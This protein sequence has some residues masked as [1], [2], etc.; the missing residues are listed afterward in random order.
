MEGARFGR[1]MIGW[2]NGIDAGAVVTDFPWD[3]LPLNT[4]V[5]DVGGGV[6]NISMQLLRKHPQLRI[7]LQDMPERIKQAKEQVWPD[8]FP[9]ALGSPND[10]AGSMIEF[11]PIDFLKESPIKDCD[12]YFL[13]NII[14]DWPDDECVTILKHIKA[15]MKADSRI[16]IHEYVVSLSSISQRPS[17]PLASD[18]SNSAD[19]GSLDLAPSPLLPNYGAGSIR[20]YNIDISVMGI[21]NSKQRTLKEFQVLGE[22]AGLRFVKLWTVGEM[23]LV[24]LGL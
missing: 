4:T 6:G 17:T 3:K 5:C 9:K 13:K 14:H 12:I 19:S 22:R 16:L 15:A 18:T 2:G 20:Q 11:K 21:L 1:G 8:M 24:E 10:G 23:G 7:K